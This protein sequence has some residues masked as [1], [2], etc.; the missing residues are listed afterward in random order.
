MLEEAAPTGTLMKG[1]QDT[2]L[3]ARK[4]LGFHAEQKAHDSEFLLKGPYRANCVELPMKGCTDLHGIHA[5][6]CRRCR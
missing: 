6:I 4:M 5:C 1:H 2:L 3:L